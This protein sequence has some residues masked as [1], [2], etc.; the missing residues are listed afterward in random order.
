M[1]KIKKNDIVCRRSYGGDILFSVERII[2][3]TRGKDYAILKGVTI[4]IEA[5]APL[6]DLQLV[7]KTII[8]SN[9]RS[10]DHKMEK[11]IKNKNARNKIE[12]TKKRGFYNKTYIRTNTGKILHL[13]GDNSFVYTSQN[14][15]N[16]G[17]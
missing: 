7:E 16:T 12:Q 3:S 4:R 11:R 15:L 5:D 8:Q 14:G 10:L 13:D 6:E 1:S 17:L 9:L 2:K